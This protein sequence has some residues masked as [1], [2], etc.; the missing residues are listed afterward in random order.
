MQ[1]M[2]GKVRAKVLGE[3]MGHMMSMH[4]QPTHAPSAALPKADGTASHS[5]PGKVEGIAVM[6]AK[7]KDP[8][9]PT[10]TDEEGPEMHEHETAE[11]PEHDPSDLFGRKHGKKMAW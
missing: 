6:S 10:G 4:G 3:L 8:M 5:M 9:H 11:A 1:D 2:D 7:G